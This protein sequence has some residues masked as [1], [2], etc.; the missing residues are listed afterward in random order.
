[1]ANSAIEIH[2]RML[3]AQKR[4]APFLEEMTRRIFPIFMNGREFHRLMYPGQPWGK[5]ITD[6]AVQ[7]VEDLRNNGHMP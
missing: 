2:M 6:D 1:M 7:M 4:M 5:P 3:E